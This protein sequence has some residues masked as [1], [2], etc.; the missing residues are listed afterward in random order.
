MKKLFFTLLFILQLAIGNLQAGHGMALVNPSFTVGPTGL[1]FTA[2]SN[3]ATCGGGPYWLQVELRCTA[4][5][6]TGTPPSTMQTNLLNWTGAGVTYNSFP[7]YNSLLNV[8]NY[9]FPTWTDNCTTEPYNP[10]FIPFTGLCPGQTYFFSAREW[11]S[12]TN[13]VGPWTAPSSFVVPGV[14]VPLNFNI[15]ASPTI[16]CLPGTSTLS[17]TSITGGCGQIS[18]LWQPGGSTLNTIVVSPA[19]STNYTCMVST[20]CNTLSKVITVSVVPNTSAIF[21]PINSSTCTGS[22][23]QFN[24]IG[25]A[26][27]SHTWAAT[28]AGATITN[29]NSINPTITFNNPGVYNISHTVA[30]GSCSNVVSSNITVTGVGAGFSINN[31]FQCLQGNSFS[32]NANSLIGTHSYSFSPLLGS[33]PIGNSS[34]YG[35]V[36]FTSPGTYTVT[37]SLTSAG[38]TASTSSLITV[39][40]TPTI[41]L[42]NNG[43]VCQGNNISINSISTATSYAWTGPGGFTSNLQNPS[44]TSISNNSGT[45]S[46]NIVDNNGCINSGTTNIVINPLPVIT[47]NT[48]TACSGG[49]FTLTATG[50]TTY[51]WSG[52]LGF[53]STLQN[54]TLSNA[55]SNM[56]GIYT[57]TVTDVNGC[58]NSNSSNITVNPSFTISSSNTGP[59]CVG[60]TITL[61]SPSGYIYNWSGPNGFTS[62]SQ[63]PILNNV[64]NTTLGQYSLTV[65]DLNGCQGSATTDVIINPNPILSIISSN[66]NICAPACVDFTLNSSTSINSIDWIFTNGMPLSSNVSTQCFNK[67]GIYTSTATVIDNKGCIGVIT[68][69]VEVYYVPTADFVFYPLKP[70]EKEEINFTD[71]SHGSIISSWN[72]YFNNTLGTTFQNPT[73]IFTDLGT[74]PVTLIVKS[75]KGCTDTITKI[76]N[77]GEDYNIYVPNSFT[78][79]GDGT[80][81]YFQP[82]GKGIVKYELMIFDRWGE[83]IFETK[84]FN[85]GWDGKVHRGVDYGEIC[86]DDVYVWKISLTNVFG[87]SHELKGHITLIK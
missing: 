58:I 57:V 3:A 73:N 52:P 8:P 31:S 45:Y 14:Y 1:T 85:Q 64:Q 27:V 69:S 59:S 18:T 77:V 83:M 6:L 40:P 22:T 54:P 65:F 47:V 38:C 20:P 81:D 75:D 60:G 67:G 43:P 76:I 84:N 63:N 29:T 26:G 86:K 10:V 16:F 23:V 28:P 62:S 79:N 21:T 56:N 15:A 24:H 66:G 19:V 32:F 61:T 4:G 46:V 68:H 48:P 50:G 7:W 13:S 44:I 25:T 82:K 55:S 36:S 34:S 17:A 30:I 49:N 39:N 12:G 72:W 87:K 11:V 78:P 70:I 35:P 9:N 2:S 53:T 51:N 42:S 41:S 33:P 71:A 5:Q 37:H 74:Y 80:N